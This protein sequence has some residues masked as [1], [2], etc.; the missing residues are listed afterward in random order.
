MERNYIDWNMSNWITIVL[1]FLI[2]CVVINLAAM[3]YDKVTG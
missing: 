2:A 3:G 1:M